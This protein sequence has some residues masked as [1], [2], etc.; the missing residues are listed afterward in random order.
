MTWQAGSLLGGNASLSGV[1]LGLDS[2][3]SSELWGEIPEAGPRQKESLDTGKGEEKIYHH[4]QL[5]F[6]C[7]SSQ[8]Q[9]ANRQSLLV[10]L[11]VVG[12]HNPC[13]SAVLRLYHQQALGHQ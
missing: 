12:S 13:A 6:S 11:S 3:G 1:R 9:Y 5:T 10:S 4:S 7:S 2:Q 8:A